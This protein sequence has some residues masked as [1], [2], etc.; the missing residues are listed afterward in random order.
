MVALVFTVVLNTYYLLRRACDAVIKRFKMSWLYR[1]V[2]Y[3]M[4]WNAEPASSRPTETEDDQPEVWNLL[5]DPEQ[6]SPVE[7]TY[8]SLRTLELLWRTEPEMPVA[9]RKDAMPIRTCC[10]RNPILNSSKINVVRPTSHENALACLIDMLHQYCRHNKIPCLPSKT[11]QRASEVVVQEAP[12]SVKR[13]LEIVSESN[14]SHGQ[15]NCSFSV[16]P[17]RYCSHNHPILFLM[18]V[19]A[20]LFY[21]RGIS[22][23]L[24]CGKGPVL[25][26]VVAV[27]NARDA[28]TTSVRVHMLK[29]LVPLY[30]GD[31]LVVSNQVVD[32]WKDGMV[33]DSLRF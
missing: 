4:G 17:I 16:Q 10:V 31:H 30:D 8:D 9:V 32:E 22:T 14:R 21:L 33:L 15:V 3:V 24:N 19:T 11:I 29:T 25:G 13:I 5:L 2:Q 1:F 7:L 28:N 18:P 12:T 6:S 27:A 23:P 26:H 20:S